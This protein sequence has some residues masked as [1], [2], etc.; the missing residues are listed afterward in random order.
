M[1]QLFGAKSVTLFV[2]SSQ[3]IRSILLKLV[4]QLQRYEDERNFFSAGGEPVVSFG[5][6][7]NSSKHTLEEIIIMQPERNCFNQSQMSYEKSSPSSSSSLLI[8]KSSSSSSAV[9]CNTETI[10]C[11]KNKLTGTTSSMSACSHSNQ[12]NH[13]NNSNHPTPKRELNS[14]TTATTTTTTADATAAGPSFLHAY[15]MKTRE[16]ETNPTKTLRVSTRSTTISQNQS[17]PIANTILSPL[18]EQDDVDDQDDSSEESEWSAHIDVDIGWWSRQRRRR[19]RRQGN[20]NDTTV[21]GL[22]DTEQLNSSNPMDET[23]MD[24]DIDETMDELRL[25]YENGEASLSSGHTDT[26]PNGSMTEGGTSSIRRSLRQQRRLLMKRRLM[27]EAKKAEARAA[28]EEIEKKCSVARRS[29]RFLNLTEDEDSTSRDTCIPESSSHGQSVETITPGHIDTL[30]RRERLKRRLIRSLDYA[31]MTCSKLP[32]TR[33]PLDCYLSPDCEGPDEELNQNHFILSNIN[34]HR[35]DGPYFDWLSTVRPVASPYLPQTGDRIVYLYRGHQDYLSQAWDGGHVP[36]MDSLDQQKTNCSPSPPP[37]HLPWTI[38]PDLP[39][40]LC[41]TVQKLTYHIVR[42]TGNNYSSTCYSTSTSSS[43]TSSSVVHSK[44]NTRK[45]SSNTTKLLKQ[46]KQLINLKDLKDQKFTTANNT[47]T[48]ATTSSSVFN[49]ECPVASSTSLNG[50]GPASGT[51]GGGGGNICSSSSC[52][53]SSATTTSTTSFD[54]GD[55][56]VRL[57]TLELQIDTEQPY[58]KL[59]YTK[60]CHT[61]QHDTTTTTHTT[62]TTTTKHQDDKSKQQRPNIIHVTYHDVDGI[63]EFIILRRIFDASLKHKWNSGDLF[64]CPV[65]DN[66]WWRGVVVRSL[67]NNNNN[68]ISILQPSTSTPVEHSL[69]T[70]YLVRWLDDNES[71]PCHNDSTSYCTNSND[72][73]DYNNNYYYTTELLDKLPENMDYVNSW[74]MFKWCAESTNRDN[75]DGDG[76]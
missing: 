21:T 36:L 30:S 64:I 40:F 76:G 8:H 22:H 48:T 11:N 68:N 20:T 5:D 67:S 12:A 65:G 43:S 50:A 74:D 60:C 63:L 32:L 49:N 45:S 55:S 75:D 71:F 69:N 6:E 70:T 31:V 16:D 28:R 13:H 46:S 4:E 35:W 59:T 14:S 47:T 44:K 7:F 56:F 62:T 24:L 34:V 29:R 41:C 38:W 9:H 73:T 19:T 72:T 51:S 53:L 17:N 54:D 15:L 10:H 58:T 52:S 57:I 3:D 23:T 1:E 42:I 2:I 26:N 66:S 27:R 37:T 25:I 61:E 39:E 33:I 18:D